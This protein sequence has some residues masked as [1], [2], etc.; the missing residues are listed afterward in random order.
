MFLKL[1][2]YRIGLVSFLIL[3]T[4]TVVT[5]ISVYVVMRNQAESILSKSLEASLKRNA[6]L[7]NSQIAQAID[8]TR[9][10]VSRPP[11]IDNLI[12]INEIPDGIKSKAK[13]LQVAEL[14]LAHNFSGI[15]L[16]DAQGTEVV[17]AGHL[18][19]RPALHIPINTQRNIFLLW[20]GHFIL[21]ALTDILDHQG[22][23]I[24]T[25][26]T[27]ADLKLSTDSLA[28]A[29]SIGKTGE[30]ALC[31]PSEES[32]QDMN[33]YLNSAT[34]REFQRLHRVIDDRALPMSYALDGKTGIIFAKDYLKE[35]VIAAYTPVGQLGLGMVLKI[36]QSELYGPITAPLKYIAALLAMLVI[37]GGLLLYWMMTPLVRQLFDSRRKLM[38]SAQVLQKENEKSLALLHNASDG[39]HILDVDGNIVEASDSFCDM[40]GYQRDELIGMNV[41][42]WDAKL[43]DS[44]LVAMLRHQFTE[45]ERCLFETRHRR[46]DGVIFDVEVSSL[47]LLLDGKPVLFNSSRDIS[48]RKEK[49]NELRQSKKRLEE[50]LENM[51]SGVAVYQAIQ[52]GSDFVFTNINR[53][54]ERMDNVRREDLIGKTLM[55][56]FPG[57]E[58]MGL[59]GAFRRVW[60]SGKAEHFPV[61]F[62]QDERIF[63]WREN[64]IYKLDSGEIVAIYDDVTQRMQLQEELRNERDFM[65]AIVQ[66]AGTLIL[67][68]DRNGSIVRFNRTAEEFTGYSFDE[69][70][71]KPFFWQKFILPE[72]QS[73]IKSVFD[74][75]LSGNIQARYENP[76]VAK[77]GEKRV[78]NWTNTLLF[79]DEGKMSFLIAIGADMTEHKQ[80]ESLIRMQSDALRSSF[81][82][83]AIA[84]AADPELPLIYVNPAFEEISGYP[85]SELLGRNCRFLQGED[86]DQ[87]ELAE[88]R[89]CLKEGRAG[90]ATLRNYRKDGTL[91]WNRLHIMPILDKEG[92][93][94][95]FV[96]IVNDITERK[97]ADDHLRL[98][99]GV[100]DHAEEGILITDKDGTILEANPACSRITGYDHE[101]ILGKNPRML[102]SDRQDPEFYDA[103]WLK[104]IEEGHWS[105]EVWNQR[106]NGEIYPERLTI[107][108]VKNDEGDTIRYIALFSDISNLK[109]QQQQLER[110]AHHDALTGLPNRTLLNDRLDMALAQTKRSEGRLA[111]CFMD[112]DGFKPVN[113]TFGHEAGDLLLVEVAKRMLAISRA[114]DTVSRLGGDEFVLIFQDISDETECR[115]MLSRVM[116]SIE[117][118]F[119]IKGHDIRIS[120]SIGVAFYPDDDADGDNLLRHADQA[121]YVAKQSGRGRFYFFDEV[122][123]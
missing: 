4:L 84:D 101:E 7:L 57:S 17:R 21:H 108:A 16:Y 35:K 55:E 3:V 42:R 106:K 1:D 30:I 10:M 70:K 83:V 27:E 59:L 94:T 81:N 120:A 111:A 24:G 60:Q 41:S 48:E 44:E 49:D 97:H 43:T 12:Q 76:W 5:G 73:K 88:I 62:Y 34:F 117:Q 47:P 72:Q 123:G 23:R 54:S 105:G 39:I 119:N 87:P 18:L 15:S 9:K 80:T 77:N 116:D 79:D 37:I 122:K 113:D 95:Q 69:V 96:G 14:F 56:V 115:Q 32:P 109:D 19:Q 51:S 74:S 29:I 58:Q 93:I 103:M 71:N 118:P 50:L 102:R 46:K 22:R 66:S 11:V 28:N 45:K 86:R 91:F 104:V 68:I 92:R 114:T 64:Y 75:A 52:D 38:D 110:M 121:M 13:L 2:E 31:G 112:L 99:S 63:G 107:S 98:I 61:S 65:D 6:N 25:L 100:F 85:A 53:A 40:L 26:M 33:C 82:G 67:V 89:A 78:F 8:N 20:D 90:R 36:N